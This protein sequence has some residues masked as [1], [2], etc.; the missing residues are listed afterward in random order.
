MRKMLLVVVFLLATYSSQLERT[1][2][3]EV[4]DG[5]YLHPDGNLVNLVISKKEKAKLLAGEVSNIPMTSRIYKTFTDSFDFLF[6]IYDDYEKSDSLY[7]G[8]C[9][10]VRN[11][12]RGI[13][14]DLFDRSGDYGSDGKLQGIVH[15]TRNNAIREGPILH[16]LMHVWANEYLDTG[17]DGHWGYTGVG[18]QLGGF[19]RLVHVRDNFYK[20]FVERQTGFSLRS[21]WG[22]S[23]P[24]SP[25]E[26]YLMGMI[27]PEEVPPIPMAVDPK[28]DPVHNGLFTA[29]RIDTV[30]IEDLIKEHGPRQPDHIQARLSFR[31]L[32]V[33]VSDAPVSPSLFDRVSEDVRLFAL[34]EQPP[35]NWRHRHNWWGKENFFSAT[36]G[37]ACMELGYLE[38]VLRQ[39]RA[40]ALTVNH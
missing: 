21:N 33:L 36:G 35:R 4:A 26:L 31:G 34:D 22:N 5:L 14:K 11:D 38:E 40:N 28:G 9:F 20:G 16:E 23:L 18:G 25:L 8:K 32:V 17:V 19:Q 1:P 29:S 37:R 3:F 10:P 6:F 24:Y 13:G 15:L 27:P 12:V 7:Y 2:G 39:P 30:C